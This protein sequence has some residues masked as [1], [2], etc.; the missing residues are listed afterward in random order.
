MSHASP[1]NG[2]VSRIGIGGGRRGIPASATGVFIRRERSASGVIR[3][4]TAAAVRSL[5]E[6]ATLSGV[7]SPDPR[8]A[9]MFGPQAR[10]LRRRALRDGDAHHSGGH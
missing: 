8:I 10:A 2:S 6:R 7:L 1:T 9:R 5:A 3:P 4:E